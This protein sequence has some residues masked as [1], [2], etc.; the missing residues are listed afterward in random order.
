MNKRILYV[1]FLFSGV[2]ALIYQVVWAKYLSLYVGS[3]A[4]AQVIVLSTFMGGLA[5]GGYIFGRLADRVLSPLKLYVYLEFGIGVYALFFHLVFFSS[6]AFFLSAISWLGL[7]PGTLLYLKIAACMLTILLPTTL[8]GGTLPALGRHMLRHLH[9]IGPRISL[10]YFCNSLGGVFGCLLAGFYLIQTFGLQF[11]VILAGAINIIIGLIA[12]IIARDSAST[13]EDELQEEE[14]RREKEAAAIRLPNWVF[15]ALLTCV[16][17]SGGVSLVYEVV[18]IRLLNLVLGGS[19]FSFTLML[20]TFI[21]GLSMGGF[22][23]SLRKKPTH[24]RVIFGFSELAVGLLILLSLPFYTKLPFYFNQLTTI[25]RNETYS[26]GIYQFLKFFL[27]AA[28]MFVPTI[29]QGITLPAAT[30]VLTRDLRTVG[31]RIGRI[32][33]INTIGTVIGSIAAGFLLIPWLGLQRTL[34]LA[35]YTNIVLAIVILSTIAHAVLRKRCLIAAIVLT[36]IMSVWYFGFGASWNRDALAFGLFRM[37]ERLSYSAWMKILETKGVLYHHDSVDN[38]VQVISDTG[39]NLTLY[40]NGKADASSFTDMPTQKTMAHLPLLLHPNPRRILIV[41]V[42]SGSMIGAATMY[43]EVEHIDVVELSHNIV[44]ASKLF[45]DFNHRYW[46]DDRV[47]IYLEDA[48]TFL[49]L[50]DNKYDV[51]ISEPTN[52]WVAGIASVFSSEYY[53][54]C[55]ARLHPDGFFVHWNQF[56]ELEDVIFLLM[57]ET[58]SEIFP[59]FTM[60]QTTF[61]DIIYLGAKKTFSH[62]FAQMQQ[63]MQQDAVRQDLASYDND[64]LTALLGMQLVDHGRQAGHVPW[65]GVKHSDFFPI[66]E[67]EAPLGLFLRKRANIPQRLDQ[68]TDRE[69]NHRLWLQ[70]YLLQHTPTAH[71]FKLLLNRLRI[72]ANPLSLQRGLVELWRKT[73]PD[74]VQAAWLHAQLQTSVPSINH[75]LDRHVQN[76]TNTQQRLE[77]EQFRLQNMIQRYNAVRCRYYCA[78]PAP[79]LTA[80]EQ[81]IQHHTYK[82]LSPLIQLA[83]GTLLFDAGRHDAAIQSWHK[84]LTIWTAHTPIMYKIMLAE[85][86]VHLHAARGENNE[87]LKVLQRITSITNK[88]DPGLRLKMLESW[89]RTQSK[90]SPKE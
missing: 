24:Y 59:N 5:L 32:F 80:I 51:I 74:D 84:A 47:H 89:L 8:M 69:L 45:A 53:A 30:K 62:N 29:L 72:S 57:L 81:T 31:S 6:R 27:C 49:Q 37:K 82:K 7:T 19:T 14:Q 2:S 15:I 41:G 50:S 16:A 42:G 63:R 67:Y 60:W 3:T 56:Y 28:V 48:K 22:L 21:L 75:D 25:L 13:A 17:F 35:V 77:I 12:L 40:V 18:W 86:L 54:A 90:P 23:L 20:G 61:G 73:Y 11:S 79:L 68:R 55:K 1:C 52:P 70:D 26:F 46:E 64:S 87:A 4:I 33:A 36:L 78:D 39:T 34:E 38:T 76:L 10:L 88:L 44:K 43:S 71:D 58:Y 66:L 9:V 83:H 65:T 85:R